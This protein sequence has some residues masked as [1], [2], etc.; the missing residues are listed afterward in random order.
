MLTI[1][2]HNLEFFSDHGLHQGEELTGNKFKV[3]VDIDLQVTQPV[4]HLSQSLD[5]AAAFEVVKKIMGEREPLLETLAGKIIAAIHELH[6]DIRK[7][8]V[9]ILKMNP[10]IAGFQGEVGLTMQSEF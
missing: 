5:Y 8:R 9:S 2:L 1:H 7:V 6:T 4:S 10:P 3:S